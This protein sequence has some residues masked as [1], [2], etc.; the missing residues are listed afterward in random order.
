MK[1][2]EGKTAIVTGAARG[3]GEATARLFAAHGASVILTDV[4]PEVH[5]VARSIGGALGHAHDVS[6]EAA[7]RRIVDEGIAAFGKIDILVNNAAIAHFEM[8]ED[9][10]KAT[11][12]RIV[13]VNLIGPFL[14]MKVVLPHMYSRGAGA[15]VNISSV[16]GLRGTTGMCA[17]DATKWGV[18]GMTKTIALEASPRGV[19]VNSIHPGAIHTRMLDPEDRLDPLEAGQRYGIALGRVGEARE[20]AAASLFLVSD[21]ASYITGAE[22]A[23]DGGWT[24]GL[25]VNPEMP[26]H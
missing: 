26:P 13:A 7:W 14:G 6:D 22:L 25:T 24:A 15:I 4:Q 17:Y 19:R 11:F 20:V 10:E 8:I 1:R 2:L 18:R 16:N 5:A 23:V 21:D 3:Q 12:E 9:T